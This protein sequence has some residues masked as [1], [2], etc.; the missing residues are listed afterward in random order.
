M[1][2]K[3]PKQTIFLETPVFFSLLRIS[4]GFLMKN[5][6]IHIW[7]WVERLLSMC[8][9]RILQLKLI[10]QLLLRKKNDFCIIL[11]SKVIN[12]EWKWHV[13]LTFLPRNSIVHSKLVKSW[14][15]LKSYNLQYN[16]LVCWPDGTNNSSTKPSIFSS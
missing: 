4:K 1:C 10:G 13:A 11:T 5:L 2:I 16:T 3:M 7:R 14:S 8:L 15:H 6:T 12:K 9:I